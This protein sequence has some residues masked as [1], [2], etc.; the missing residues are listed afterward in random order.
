MTV[1]SIFVG[2]PQSRYAAMAIITAV[3]VV[4]LSIVFGAHAMPLSQK[5]IFII[6]ISLLSIPGILFSLLQLTCLVTGAGSNDKRWWCSLYAWLM[7]IM[8]IIYS[9]VI[10]V[11]SIQSLFLNQETFGSAHNMSRSGANNVIVDYPGH[12]PFNDAVDQSPTHQH[13]PDILYNSSAT[14]DVAEDLLPFSDPGLR[15]QYMINQ[16]LKEEFTIGETIE[17][18]PGGYDIRLNN[19]MNRSSGNSMNNSPTPSM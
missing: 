2:S 11:V 6:L 4:S 7:S 5:F 19:L 10:V 1:S 18:I 14:V 16:K 8:I 15:N 3:L 9:I 12:Y 17:P 13:P